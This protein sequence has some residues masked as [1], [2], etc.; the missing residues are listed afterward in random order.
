[1]CLLLLHQF[2][3]STFPGAPG[4]GSLRRARTR[5]MCWLGSASG[6]GGAK[7]LGSGWVFSRFH[8]L[9]WLPPRRHRAAAS[10]SPCFYCRA[11]PPACSVRSSF[12]PP[13]PLSRFAFLCLPCSKFQTSPVFPGSKQLQS[14]FWSCAAR[15]L[16]TRELLTFIL[17]C[18]LYYPHVHFLSRDAFAHITEL[19]WYSWSCVFLFTFYLGCGVGSVGRG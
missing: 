9:S 11:D 12:L 16:V 18:S 6:S 15:A 14:S 7:Q 1:M 8:S 10:R 2:K 3:P 19:L 5:R 17:K 4:R 13:S